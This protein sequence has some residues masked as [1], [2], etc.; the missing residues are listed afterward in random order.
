[1]S[2]KNRHGRSAAVFILPSFLPLVAFL[3]VPMLAAVTLSFAEWD[4]LTPPSWIGI[5]NYVELM[6]SAVFW[7]TLKN[8]LVFIV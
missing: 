5:Q 2:I 7:Q 3:I 4:L 6:R 8:S 1:M